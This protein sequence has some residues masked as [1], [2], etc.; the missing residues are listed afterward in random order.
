M[1]PFYALQFLVNRCDKF[2]I[3][4]GPLLAFSANTLALQW[5]QC[6]HIHLVLYIKRKLPL[7]GVSYTQIFWRKVIFRKNDKIL[8]LLLL[9]YKIVCVC[10]IHIQMHTVF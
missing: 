5:A 3:L 6:S 4:T 7:P 2:Y 8:S 1:I 10:E 9:L